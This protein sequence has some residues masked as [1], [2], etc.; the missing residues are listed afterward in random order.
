MTKA[1]TLEIAGLTDVGRSRNHNEDAIGWR[2]VLGL[3]VL[4]DG[5]GGHNAGEVASRIAVDTVIEVFEQTDPARPAD[6]D[7]LCREAAGLANAAIYS[8]A[9]E[10]PDCQGMGTTLVMACFEDD[11]LTVAHVGDSRLYR[12]RDGELETL[13]SDHSLVQEM[14]DS[15]F[16]TEEEA[17]RSANRNMITRALG[18][19]EKVDVD[20][21]RQQCQ[22][23]D[24][25]L[26]CSDGLNDLVARDDIRDILAAGGGE[27]QLLCQ[28]LVDKANARGGLDNISVILVRVP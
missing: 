9:T 16:L 24:I 2:Q 26:L 27:L 21:A 13:T 10:D 28:A 6:V 15:G 8:R 22:A 11:G 25:Y 14:I 17:S 19:E 23:G 7:S 5:M 3:A 4:A 18:V 20:V 1:K 12:F